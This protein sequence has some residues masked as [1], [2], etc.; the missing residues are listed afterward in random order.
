MQLGR[1]PMLE[2]EFN[3]LFTREFMQYLDRGLGACVLR[4]PEAAQI[5]ADS[6]L[7]F[8]G[9]RY[10]MSDFVVMPNHV[11]A[12]FCLLGDREIEAQCY[13][14]KKFTAERINKFLGKK[15]RFWQEESF[16]HLVRSAEQFEYLRKYIAEN[17]LKAGLRAGEF[18]LY[19]RMLDAIDVKIRKP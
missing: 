10:W 9:V 7:H 16:D 1:M 2:R 11:H 17:P 6:F 15:G 14:W 18:I 8:D 13:S 3:L 5:V 4:R 19:S 12:L